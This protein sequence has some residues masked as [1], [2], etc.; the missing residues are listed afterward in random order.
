MCQLTKM[1]E[2]TLTQSFLFKTDALVSE[3][4]QRKKENLHYRKKK[5]NNQF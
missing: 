3:L 2:E 5:E 4:I 1:W